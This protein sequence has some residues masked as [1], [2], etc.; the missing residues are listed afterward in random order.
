[1]SVVASDQV[2]D[3]ASC[4]S[5]DDDAQAPSS[6][7]RSLSLENHTIS[8]KRRPVAFGEPVNGIRTIFKIN[9]S[10]L[11]ALLTRDTFT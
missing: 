8:S 3:M 5:D 9:R 6:V 1:M 2:G 4:R 11:L 7:A 10:K